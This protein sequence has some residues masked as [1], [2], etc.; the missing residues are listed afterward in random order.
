M[1]EIIAVKNNSYSFKINDYLKGN[2]LQV[3][4][5]TMFEEW[6]CDNRFDKPKI[7]QKLCLFLKKKKSGWEIS[8]GSTGEIL[9]KENSITLNFEEYKNTD[10]KYTPYQLSLVEFKNGI[11]DFCNCYAFIGDYNYDNPGYF[12]LIGNTTQ[13]SNLKVSSK[14]SNWLSD[15]MKNY[16]IKEHNSKKQN[17]N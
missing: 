2:S 15:K 14:F 7:G 17:S 16:E 8:N 5:V 3:I 1:G 12:M 6:T 4:L 13:L 10:Y 9:I 11:R